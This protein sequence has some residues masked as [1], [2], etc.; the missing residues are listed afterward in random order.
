MHIGRN[1]YSEKTA[2]DFYQHN[3]VILNSIYA[4]KLDMNSI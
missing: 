1:N 3:N 4:K 2:F